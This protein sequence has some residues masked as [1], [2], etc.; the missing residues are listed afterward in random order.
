MSNAAGSAIVDAVGPPRE[1]SGDIPAPRR[2]LVIVEG[3]PDS[4]GAVAQHQADKG[5]GLRSWPA[6]I[7]S[8]VVLLIGALRRRTTASSSETLFTGG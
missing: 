6:G 3:K 1:V 2:Y 8:S 4:L 7:F 5:C